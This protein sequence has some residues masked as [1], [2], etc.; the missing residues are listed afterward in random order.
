MG[1][2]AQT[3]TFPVSLFTFGFSLNHHH[4]GTKPFRKLQAFTQCR[5]GF[6]LLMF[7]VPSYTLSIQHF[8]MGLKAQTGTFPVSLFTFDF[9]LNHRHFGTK[10][11]RKLQA[12]T[13]RRTGFSVSHSTFLNGLES[14]DWHFCRFT[15]HVRLFLKSSPLRYKAFPQAPSLHSAPHWFS[16][17][18]FHV[19]RFPSR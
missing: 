10:P 16:L 7:C 19:L 13:Q 8:P 17:S 18:K 4:F 12:F 15:F 5:T 14:S 3:G 11:F 1:L 2:K 6:S 9:S